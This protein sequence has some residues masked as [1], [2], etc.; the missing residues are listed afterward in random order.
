[1]TTKSRGRI[2]QN[3]FVPFVPFVSFVVEGLGR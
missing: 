1:M 2:V 3:F